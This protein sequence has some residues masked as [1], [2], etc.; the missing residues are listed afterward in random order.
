MKEVTIAAFAGSLRKESFNRHLVEAVVRIAPQHLHINLLDI[1]DI[2]LFIEDNELPQPP[3]PVIRF[4]E[5]L[6]AAD[7]ILIA[8]PEYNRSIPGVLKN[9]LDW[10]SGG[11]HGKSALQGKPLAIIGA[12]N[13]GFGTVCAQNHLLF[14]GAHMNM[15]VWGKLRLQVSKAADKFDPS[16]ELTDEDTEKRLLTLLNDFYSFIVGS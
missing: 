5:Q 7:G 14:L 1:A 9:T 15:K 16:G 4:K 13:G 2:P 10:V 3:D 8:T 11:N 12:S 6:L